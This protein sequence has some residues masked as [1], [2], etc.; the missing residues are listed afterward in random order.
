MMP[1]HRS[2]LSVRPV[3]KYSR[4]EARLV[5]IEKLAPRFRGSAGCSRKLQHRP[6][7]AEALEK[8]R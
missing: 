2:S 4:I 8:L 7:K 1:R 6:E 3:R 5:T